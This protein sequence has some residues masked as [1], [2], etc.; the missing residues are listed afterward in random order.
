LTDRADWKYKA[1]CIFYEVALVLETNI[2]IFYWT[3]VFPHPKKQSGGA[4]SN[5]TCDYTCLC[6]HL[7]GLVGLWLDTALN[8]QVIAWS[9]LL[10]VATVP[11]VWLV[12][13]AVWVWTGHP[14]CYAILTLK[15]WHEIG[16]LCGVQACMVASFAGYYYLLRWRATTMKA[17]SL[18]AEMNSD[19]QGTVDYFSSSRS[20]PGFGFLRDAGVSVPQPV[21]AG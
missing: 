4:N 20:S 21:T 2:V 15:N 1:T 18:H 14:N 11:F 16:L 9:H 17:A 19:V 6:V 10:A 12:I 13:Q 3:L 7:A 5:G 8:K